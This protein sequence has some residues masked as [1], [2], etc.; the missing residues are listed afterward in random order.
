MLVGRGDETSRNSCNSVSYVPCPCEYVRIRGLINA[1]R[2]HFALRRL[3]LVVET[4]QA[5]YL[6]TP[7]VSCY[8]P[9]SCT[10]LLGCLHSSLGCLAA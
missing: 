4:G 3:D 6:S 5:P 9:P 1:Y 10:P 8:H 2:C 7:N